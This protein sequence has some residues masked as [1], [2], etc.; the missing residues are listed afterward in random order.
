M[1][2][3]LIRALLLSLLICTL[4]ACS[5]QDTEELPA[6][7]SEERRPSM[8]Y[9]L[10]YN[11][12]A[13]NTY[14][15]W[16]QNS[17]PIGNSFIGGN[18]FGR[19]DTERITLNEKTFWT[20][21]PSAGRPD[22]M[23][24]NLPEKGKN[25]KT[26]AQIQELFLS[27]KEEEGSR[28]CEDLVG[29]WDGYGGYQLFGSLWLDFG[30]VDPS[31]ITDYSRS[32]DLM[33][34][35][36]GVIYD[37]GAAHYEREAFAS[38]EDNVM[39]LHLTAD[40]GVL[41]FRLRIT[42]A[43]D[44]EAPRHTRIQA[45]DDSIRLT[46][47]LNDNQLN[48]AAFVKVLAETGTVSS[49]DGESLCISGAHQVTIILSMATDYA[50]K[51][52]KYRTG[53]SADEL[54]ARVQ[55]TVEQASSKS[56]SALRNAHIA[57]F[58]E[59]MYRVDLSLQQTES[60]LPTDRL[61]AEYR[62]NALAPSERAYLEV[63]LYQYGRYLLVSSSRG[64]TLPANLQGLWV[65][66]NG[67]AWSSD[68]HINVNLQ[69]NYWLACQTNLAECALPLIDYVDS[70][71]QPGRI[72]AEIYFGV[73][74]TEENPENGFT[75]NTQ[76]T[77]FGWTCPG[78]SFDWGWSPAAVPWILQNVWEY[79]EYTLDENLLRETIYPMM[80]EQVVF[81]RQI[82]RRDAD[83]RW[84]S[85]P[86]YSP[87][88]GP[89]TNGNTYEQTLIWQLFT[90]TIAAGEIVGEEPSVL[91]EWQSILDDLR[92]PVE[93][94]ADGQIKEWYEETFIGSVQ[95][96]EPYKHR[97]LSHLLGLFPGD[98]ISAETPEWFEA[99]RVSLDSRTDLSTGWA[100]GQ[101]INTWARL[102]DGR[103]AYTLIQMLIQNGI[104]DNLWDTH[105]PFQI[106]GNFGYTAGV[107]ECL[108]Q[109]N[110]GC[111]NILPA[112]PP[113]WENG[114]V[115]GIVARGSFELD[116]KW[117]NGIPLEIT[118]LSRRGGACTIQLNAQKTF[119][120]TDSSGAPVPY[121]SL[122]ENR[123]RFETKQGESYRIVNI[124]Y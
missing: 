38:F 60:S 120:V 19:Y 43:N 3:R 82:L 93:I 94:G 46:G 45:A 58:T 54:A 108:L 109:S 117:E 65:G 67:S 34:G 119:I 79:Y 53:E 89:R 52:P 122:R 106:D 22:Y 62:K 56:Y 24:G 7:P 86:A 69:M 20:G 11:T 121:E 37:R 10:W 33:T 59:M 103:H 27:G 68:Y 115:T 61:L 78:W 14:D 8:D 44:S 1:T 29:A 84:I 83:G 99:A 17:L 5:R 112:L 51:Y 21:G 16:E 42:P 110:L 101:R 35:I 48:Y 77:P 111:L 18:L 49:P 74:S 102:G 123:F 13:E 87:E 104:L 12:P 95:H 50:N 92:T 98:L 118:V 32:L 66:K 15:G 47:V 25:G 9:R 2:H 97:H 63:L 55:D 57:D 75:A 36:A 113:E 96:S 23:G 80:K 41:D 124:P 71:R 40:G 28:L 114:R 64:D 107:T 90:D 81:Y 88:H 100:M 39:V 26:L 85:T 116:L 105:P 72:T 70:L 30:E 31:E 6:Q 91:Q 73:S 4:P 76:T